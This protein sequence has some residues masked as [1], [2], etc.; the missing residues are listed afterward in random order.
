MKLT[1]MTIALRPLAQYLRCQRA[2]VEA[3][4]RADAGVSRE[5]RIELSVADIDGDD[6]RRAA[7]KQDIGKASG[8]SADVEADE[9][10]RIEPEGVE[11]GGELDP[12]ARRPGVGR[13]GF[14]RRVPRDLLRRFP[15]RDAANG[16]QPG[17]DRGLSAR[18]A[19]KEAALDENEY[20]RACA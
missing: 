20:P 10:R 19:R 14:D 2:R 9:T 11:R 6:L 1:S 17:G 18:P 12:A 3:F 7:R 16:D 15:K 5:A 13:L 8:R 4:Q